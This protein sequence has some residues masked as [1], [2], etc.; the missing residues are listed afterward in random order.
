M[1]VGEM[2]SE[3]AN[4]IQSY[5]L[6]ANQK[7]RRGA[8]LLLFPCR[9]PAIRMNATFQVSPVP[10]TSP[11]CLS[12]TSSSTT[13]KVRPTDLSLRPADREKVSVNMRA[14]LTLQDLSSP[15]EHANEE[16]EPKMEILAHLLV[17]IRN[18]YGISQVLNAL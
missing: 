6:G 3:K 17:I 5:P 1:D 10:T 16:K 9:S 12:F 4:Q 14:P 11:P 18:A 7:L 8:K 13:S 2:E 15:A